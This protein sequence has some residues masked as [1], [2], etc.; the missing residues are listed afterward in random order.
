MADASG[1]IPLPLKNTDNCNND[2]RERDST[3]L[4]SHTLKTLVP[5]TSHFKL[6][7]SDFH[8]VFRT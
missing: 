8:E 6:T 4:E 7:G 2:Q 5:V 1:W 3:Q